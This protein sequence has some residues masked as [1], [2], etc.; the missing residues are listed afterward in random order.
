MKLH[1][2]EI[3]NFRSVFTDAKGRSFRT[4][5]ADGMNVIVGPNNSGKSN[6]LRG[7]ALALDPAA[8]FDRT[9][10]LPGQL[11]NN[12]VPTIT[13]EFQRT[14][15]AGPEDTLFRYAE[16]YERS[17]LEDSE[18]SFAADGRIRI[19]VQL[20]SGESGTASRVERIQVRGKGAIG[21]DP[22]LE[23]KV[24]RQL[25][26]VVRFVYIESGSDVRALLRGRFRDILHAV[27]GEHRKSEL[28][29]ARA[30]QAQFAQDLEKQLLAPLSKQIAE[31][32]DVMFSDIR[33]VDL[34]PSMP[35][36][37]QMLE[38]VTI[39]LK[40][41]VPTAL[42]S[43][44]TGIRGGVLVALLRYLAE[45]SRRSIVFAIEEPEAFLHPA[46]QEG[47]RHDIHEL[48][49]RDDCSVIVTTHSP[50][51]VPSYPRSRVVAV[52]KDVEGRTHVMASAVGDDPR[53]SVM[54]GLFRDTGLAAVIE[55]ANQ[56]PR[57]A[58]AILFVEGWTDLRYLQIAAAASGRDD[59]LQAIHIV[60]C[61][62]TLRLIT[63]VVVTR[64]Q[65]DLP[66]VILLDSDAPGN[67]AYDLLCGRRFGFSKKEQ[68]MTYAEAYSKARNVEVEAEDLFS[69]PLTERFLATSKV[70]NLVAG[71]PVICPHLK[72]RRWPFSTAGKVEFVR[73]LEEQ[74]K[75]PE[76]P[77]WVRLIDEIERRTAG[78]L[79]AAATNGG[80][81]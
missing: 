61:S 50:Y 26:D 28:D 51:L 39:Q 33:E 27:L 57:K 63:E 2:L 78:P 11:R 72:R 14:Q 37:D 22:D 24:I 29:R 32:L 8:V 5:L 75:L 47:M 67:E 42:A 10:D 74:K 81:A 76:L 16:T 38:G 59:W 6:I 53:A 44:G 68:L 13:L 25:R 23:Q 73:Y 66:F 49:T 48:A 56:V 58:R 31:R 45:Q 34:V 21:G 65:T 9:L 20:R 17:K 60:P 35:S 41:S 71:E 43:K 3:K 4:E 1:S 52:S 7:L 64:A 18:P 30:L 79:D 36:I 46:A 55:R 12:A 62:G 40:D 69:V 54:S 19:Q 70:L 77:V 80:A 15:A